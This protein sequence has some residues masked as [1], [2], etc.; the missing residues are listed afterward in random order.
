MTDLS[1]ELK[2]K[3][4]QAKSA[5]EAAALVKDAGLD[6]PSAEQLWKEI[7]IRREDQELSLDEL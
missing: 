6:E 4:I 5:E 1:Y 2:A 7:S 3:L